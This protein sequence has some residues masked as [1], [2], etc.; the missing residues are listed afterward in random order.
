MFRWFAQ[1]VSV[2]RFNLSTLPQRIGSSLTAMVGVAG[3]VA[4]TVAVLSIAQGI[5]RTM[6]QSASEDNVVIPRGFRRH[7]PP[8]PQH[9][10]RR[11]RTDARRGPDGGRSA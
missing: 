11:Q 6:E 3:V 1:I 9:R 5:L 2:T 10:D 8:D 4:V 7:R